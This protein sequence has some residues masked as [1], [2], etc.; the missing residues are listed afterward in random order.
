MLI[1]PALR[2]TNVL[3]RDEGHLSILLS[4]RFATSLVHELAAAEGLP[5]YG[6]ALRSISPAA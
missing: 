4:R 3:I 1:E 2:A 5:G 6:S